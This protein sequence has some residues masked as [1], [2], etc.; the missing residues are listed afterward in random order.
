M[1]GGKKFKS[2]AVNR[3]AV[4]LDP[5]EA[6]AALAATMVIPISPEVTPE[7]RELVDAVDTSIRPKIF[8][9]FAVVLAL[10]LIA[11]TVIG[12]FWVKGDPR[13]QENWFLF[14]EGRLAEEYKQRAQALYEREEKVDKMTLNR[15]GDITLFYS[16]R[17]SKVKVTEITYSE[18]QKEFVERY[19]RGGEDKRKEVGRR[20]LDQI[21]KK[22]AELKED[23]YFQNLPV[24][25]LPV[26]EREADGS[27][28]TFEYEIE[29]T[30][31]NASGKPDYKPRRYL[32]HSQFSY[33]PPPDGVTPLRF[34]DQGGGSF[35][36]PFMGA[37][38]IP[39]PSI[40]MCTYAEVSFA[41]RCDFEWRTR[42]EAEV[43]VTEPEIPALKENLQMQYSGLPTDEF[44]ERVDELTNYKA[45][46]D[47]WTHAQEMAAQCAC[48]TEV[49]V[50]DPQDPT[51]KIKQPK[52]LKIDNCPLFWKQEKDLM[53]DGITPVPPEMNKQ[54]CKDY[55]RP[56]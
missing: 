49:E 32:L 42:P 40:F 46:P 25:N 26:V 19:V 11:A 35:R 9:A 24:K 28:K 43:K 12:A 31:V 1:A 47:A 50:P 3:E 44:Q 20:E 33:H 5:T 7:E 41:A 54:Y 36:A 39:E 8:S 37:D 45:D 56:V 16:P 51:K 29:I 52:E 18:A 10:A 15:Y 23:Q 22:T 48:R 27:M 34:Q 21:G 38:L 53:P 55:K 6:N 13:V 4:A 17:D 14:W 2:G 30:H